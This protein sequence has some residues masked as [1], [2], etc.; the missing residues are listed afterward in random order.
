MPLTAQRPDGSTTSI[1]YSDRETF[2]KKG[3]KVTGEYGK[4][5]AQL[6]ADKE[7]REEKRDRIEEK[8]NKKKSVS[9]SG[10]NAINSATNS[11]NTC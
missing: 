8:Q 3:Y 11:P 4:S 2:E 1:N 5:E 7:A 9:S 6:K 10:S